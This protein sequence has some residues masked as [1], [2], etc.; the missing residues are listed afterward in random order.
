MKTISRRQS[1]I[2]R[3]LKKVYKL[4]EETREHC[5]SG[6]GRYDVPLSHSHIIP[7]SRNSSIDM[8]TNP[9]NIKYHCLSFVEANGNSR[10]GCHDYWGG[11]PRDKQKLLDYWENMNF[12]KENDEEYYNILLID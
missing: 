4:I 11:G 3:E 2:N 1:K 9:K 10:I 12:L 6:C 8:Q 5:C 7:R